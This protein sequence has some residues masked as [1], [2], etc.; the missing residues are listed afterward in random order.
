MLSAI[1]AHI[2]MQHRKNTNGQ[3][4]FSS[5]T[6][7]ATLSHSLCDLPLITT[8]HI[9]PSS[10]PPAFSFTLTTAPS[11]RTVVTA[12][13]CLPSQPTQAA[14]GLRMGLGD[15]AMISCQREGKDTFCCLGSIVGPRGC[16]PACLES[17]SMDPSMPARASS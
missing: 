5:P 16:L 17:S 9:S 1:L 2:Y 12:D 3:R 7:P 14:L 15:R 11:A 6:L 8:S 13:L 10:S 4:P